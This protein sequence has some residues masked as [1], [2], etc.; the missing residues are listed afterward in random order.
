MKDAILE[1][2]KIQMIEKR[3]LIQVCHYLWAGCLSVCT[4][5][6]QIFVRMLHVCWYFYT[7]ADINA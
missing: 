2:R 4:N 1:T 7:D 6:N 3:Q 5:V